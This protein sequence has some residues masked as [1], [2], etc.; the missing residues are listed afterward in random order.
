MPGAGVICCESAIRSGVGLVKLTVPK[1]AYPIVASHL[2]Q[3]IFNPVEDSNGIYSEKP[4]MKY[5][6]ICSGQVRL[7]LVAVWVSAM[8]QEKSPNLC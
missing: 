8:I 5:Q 3:P 6:T 2:V 4:L 1:S 7:F